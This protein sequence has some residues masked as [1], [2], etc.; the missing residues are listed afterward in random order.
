M[1]ASIP[2][3]TLCASLG[4]SDALNR[5]CFCLTLD[6]GALAKALDSQLGRPGLSE[7][8]QQRCPYLFAAQP[9]FVATGDVIRFDTMLTRNGP[10]PSASTGLGLCLQYAKG[11]AGTPVIRNRAMGL[12]GESDEIGME[13]CD[14]FRPWS[15]KIPGADRQIITG[16]LSISATWPGGPR[17][18]RQ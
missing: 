6:E 9:V 13:L 17:E 2:S 11:V 18:V 14:P 7:M 15:P 3:S 4:S 12:A 1:G 10:N 5:E 8:V 16:W